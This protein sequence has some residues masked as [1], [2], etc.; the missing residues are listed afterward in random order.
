MSTQRKRYSAEF[1]AWVALDAIKGHNTINALARLYGVHPSQI[2]HWKH[3]LPK[4]VPQ[5]F[6]ARRAKREHDQDD[7]QA[8][9]YQQIGQ[10]KVA[11]DWLK[12]KLVLPRDGKH[13][14]I[15]PAH[16][17]IS[18]ARQCELVGLSRS[19]FYYDAHGESAENLQLMRLL[20]EQYTRTPF[21]GIRRMRVWLR[22]H[23]YAVHPKRVARR[24][25]L[26]GLETI[27]PKPRLR[28]PHPK[29]RI[30]PDLLRGVPITRVNQVWSTDITYIRLQ[31][32]FVDLGA[33]MD[34][35]RRY[36]LS[37]AVSITMD[38]DFCL[39]ALEQAL[40]IATPAI[41]NSD[42]GAQFTSTDFTRRLETAGVNISM[43]GRGRA[44][45]NVF[46]ERLWRT[47]EYEEVYLKD[48]R[49]PREAT[50]GLAKFFQGYTTERPHQ[51]LGY[52]TPA[53]VYCDSYA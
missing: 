2:T 23:G 46:V 15:E 1:K 7:L 19:S 24:L 21:S 4:E 10:L 11:L 12:K 13:G 16:P 47:V 45:D 26:R 34:W 6:S 17:Q 27:Y 9:L 48:Y 40:G 33:V 22:Q 39:E 44:L 35:F 50:Q 42:Q 49:T 30:Y 5:I 52:H 3:Q 20:D 37:G 29:H 14:L 51:A 36:V 43:D 25:R 41:F 53:A 8:P 28:Q 38:G 32:G 31:A 18:I